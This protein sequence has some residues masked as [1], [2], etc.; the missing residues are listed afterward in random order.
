MNSHCTDI[1][2]ILNCIIYSFIY[3]TFYISYPFSGLV[4]GRKQ[5][6]EHVVG[7]KLHKVFFWRNRLIWSSSGYVYWAAVKRCIRD[8]WWGINNSVTLTR[9]RTDHFNTTNSTDDQ[10]HAVTCVHKTRASVP[11][12]PKK[13]TFLFCDCE[14]CPMSL[15]FGLYLVE[16][17]WTI[18]PDI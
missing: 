2:I 6:E 9:G 16:S 5:W 15:T 18:M 11:R 4:Q 12:Y 3:T 17:R 14:R 1:C 7:E 10:K 8:D 13:G